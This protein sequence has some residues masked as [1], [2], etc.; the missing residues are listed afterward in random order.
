[1]KKIIC[2]AALLFFSCAAFAQSQVSTAQAG[3]QEN[4]EGVDDAEA[5]RLKEIEAEKAAREN[6]YKEKKADLDLQLAK[7]T[8][9]RKIAAQDKNK[10][11]EEKRAA[12]IL[13][14]R[15]KI[16]DLEKE[17]KS[18]TTPSA[19]E[20]KPAVQ[21]KKKEPELD[22]KALQRE[23]ARE[24]AKMN[25]QNVEVSTEEDENGEEKKAPPAK[26]K[27]KKKKK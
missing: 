8:Q 13:A 9:D 3:P 10:S 14:T 6:E 21:K 12:E 1:M 27:S 4:S 15:K 23:L 2:L 26:K 16:K 25:G 5:K 19:E 24:T 20:E 22:M 7:L 17:Y 11:L 18:E